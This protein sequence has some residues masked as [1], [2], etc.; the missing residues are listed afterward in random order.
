M[1]PPLPPPPRQNS[2]YDR[3][4]TVFYARKISHGMDPPWLCFDVDA[5]PVDVYCERYIFTLTPLIGVPLQDTCSS[6][7]RFCFCCSRVLERS[8]L[9]VP[10]LVYAFRHLSIVLEI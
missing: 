6:C 10:R 5:Y 4:V 7:R 3:H 9:F 2:P 1:K 8:S